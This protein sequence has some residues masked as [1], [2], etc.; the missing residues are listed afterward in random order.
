MRTHL[1]FYFMQQ[2]VYSEHKHNVPGL[3]KF[4]HSLIYAA[5]L[6]PS[7]FLRGDIKCVPINASSCPDPNM[8]VAAMLVSRKIG[9]ILFLF[10]RS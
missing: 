4:S 2:S 10:L 3:L 1:S 5:W 9:S 8:T 7:V 6:S